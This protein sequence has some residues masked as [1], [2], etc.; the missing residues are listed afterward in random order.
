MSF[1]KSEELAI[2]Y[3]K[4]AFK[5]ED[6]GFFEFD[7]ITILYEYDKWPEIVDLLY[8]AGAIDDK[9]ISYHNEDKHEEI[10]KGLKSLALQ[11]ADNLVDFMK[12]VNAV[13]KECKICNHVHWADEHRLNDLENLEECYSCG[14]N[15]YHVETKKF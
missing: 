15:V 6:G 10:I 2:N 9:S 14:A 5:F 7:D 11:S 3:L 13:T 12:S 1:T 4:N 8:G